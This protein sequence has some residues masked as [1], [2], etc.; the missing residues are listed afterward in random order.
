MTPFEEKVHRVVSEI[1]R[2]RIASYGDVAILV[3][4][5]RSARAVG[6]ALRHMDADSEIPWW[7]V[8]NGRGVISTTT[9]DHTAQVQRA[10]LEAEGVEFDASGQIDWKR[11]GWD[12]ACRAEE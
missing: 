2:G 8:V 7:R 11:F 5:P 10:L 6:N 9:I 3:G 1:P 4:H 12:E